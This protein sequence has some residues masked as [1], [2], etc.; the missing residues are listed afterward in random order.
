MNTNRLYPIL[1]VAALLMTGCKGT[2]TAEL[3]DDSKLAYIDHMELFHIRGMEIKEWLD[4][5]GKNVSHYVIIDDMDNF[6]PEQKSHF[7]LT[8]PEVGITD[9]DA[10][11]AIKILN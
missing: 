11:K 8:D 4:K 7:V 3:A 6:F 2:K 5:H 10:D 9:E 1:L